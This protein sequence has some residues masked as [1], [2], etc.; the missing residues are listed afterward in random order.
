MGGSNTTTTSTKP[1]DPAVTATLDKLLGGV[2]T[3]YDKGPSVFNQSLYGGVGPTTSNAWSSALNAASNPDYASGANGA[4]A[5]YAGVAAGNA[6]GQNDPGYAALR[7]KLSN[8]VLTST[9][10][11]FNNSGLFGSDTNQQAAASGLA[12]SL[13]GLDY[14]QYQDS[15]TRQN[16]AAAMLP[17]LYQAS[18]LPASTM[19]AIGSAQ[20]ADTQAALSGQNDLFNRQNNADTD[21]LTKLSSV[22]GGV[23]PIGGSDTVQT[24]PATPWWQVL[25]SLVGAFKPQGF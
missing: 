20:D 24:A 7:A 14:Q 15:L 10:S 3:A 13:G 19:G 17:Q 8:D 12:N 16:N 2:N 9:N 4:I 18:Q 1:A 5:N 22:F 25:T 11:S 23:A 21:L 6:L